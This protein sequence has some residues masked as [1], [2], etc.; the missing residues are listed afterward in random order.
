MSPSGRGPRAALAAVLSGI[1]TGLA[2]RDLALLAAG[3][4]F[5]A[6]IAIVPLLVL[7]LGLTAWLTSAVRV[8]EL[9]RRLAELLPGELGAPDAVARL[10][11]PAW[12]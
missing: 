8:E 9:G 7:A 4:T 3:L 6:G 11:E 12:G 1:R 2:G 10:V 5:Y